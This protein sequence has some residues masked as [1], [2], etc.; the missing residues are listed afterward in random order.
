MLGQ[1]AQG[2]SSGLGGVSSWLGAAGASA[3][4]ATRGLGVPGLD[5]GAG[6]GVLAGYYFGAGND[7]MANPRRR[8]IDRRER[9]LGRMHTQF[10]GGCSSTAAQ[11]GS[12]PISTPFR[13]RGDAE[14][15]SGGPSSSG[16]NTTGR[17]VCEVVQRTHCRA[18]IKSSSLGG[19]G[20]TNALSADCWCGGEC[21][22]DETIPRCRHSSSWSVWPASATSAAVHSTFCMKHQLWY[23]S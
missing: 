9:P 10:Q 21:V 4:Q 8:A 20:V 22:C 6:C 16:H 3:R 18:S 12:S 1:A 7:A 5:V 17:W 23:P 2:I 15:V 19:G 13:C 14:A 11:L